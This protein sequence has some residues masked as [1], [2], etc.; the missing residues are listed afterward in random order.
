MKKI[1]TPRLVLRAL[2]INDYF[3]IYDILRDYQTALWF[4]MYPEESP[5]VA[6]Y[7]IWR[8]S[9]DKSMRQYGII[10]KGAKTVIGVIQVTD[11]GNGEIELGYVLSKDYRRKGYM[12]EAVKAISKR[13]FYNPKVDTVS[14]R[15]LP[16]NLPSQG[17]ARKVGFVLQPPMKHYKQMCYMTKEFYDR[18]VLTRE[19]LVSD[20]AA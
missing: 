3:D 7:F 16:S 13:L 20:K 9:W 11:F 18:L 17:V 2:K 6:Q 19:S 8:S 15:V 4:G 5:I 14:L 10:E 12:T 1:R